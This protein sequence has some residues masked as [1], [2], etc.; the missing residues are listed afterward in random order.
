MLKISQIKKKG[1]CRVYLI[2]DKYILKRNI[3]DRMRAE[4]IFLTVYKGE[5]VEEVLFY[6]KNFNFAIYRY[7]NADRVILNS[8]KDIIDCIFQVKN[9]IDRYSI[10]EFQGYGDIFNRTES[11]ENFVKKE[12]KDKHLDIKEKDFIIERAINIL[13]NY[14]FKK[15][16][17]HGDLGIYN[18]I[19]KKNKLNIVIDP[20]TVIGDPLYDLIYFIFSK[21]KFIEMLS[22]KDIVNII[23]EPEEKVIAM[24][25]IILYLRISINKRNNVSTRVYENMWNNLNSYLKF[26]GVKGF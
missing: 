9:F 4:N 26:R 13:S 12:L 17:I 8:K 20:R 2:N 3:K 23:D 11:W 22:V 10:C 6:N 25:I 21:P 5:N 18:I 24:M 7:E 16:I 19:F 14:N 1:H 15:C